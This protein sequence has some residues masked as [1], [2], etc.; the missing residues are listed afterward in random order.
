MKY[1]ITVREKDNSYQVLVSYKLSNGKWR[2]KT[3]QGFDKKSLA[4][5]YGFEIVEK[6]KKEEGLNQDLSKITLSDFYELYK[7]DMKSRLRHNTIQSLD[8]TLRYFHNLCDMPLKDISVHDILKE[9]NNGTQ[10]TSS[11]NTYLGNLNTLFNYAIKP[12]KIIGYSPTADV[13]RFKV[14]KSDIEIITKEEFSIVLSSIDKEIVSYNLQ[15]AIAYYCG[16]RYGEIC[17]LTWNDINFENNTLTIN[18]QLSLTERKKYNI[19]SV[20]SK[21]SNRTIPMPPTLKS[22]LLRYKETFNSNNTNLFELTTGNSGHI[23]RW[24]KLNGINKSIHKFRHTYA[25][26]LLANGVDIRTV[27]A[28]LGDTVSTVI[29]KYIHYTDEMR[30]NA[31]TLINDIY[32]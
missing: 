16:L 24:L 27:A 6:L 5:Q 22:I 11:K 7:R 2:Q 31:A 1:N 28:L 3:K 25:T 30:R 9:L 17:A 15:C 21:N 19:G 32:K 29:N 20:K 13:K 10:K 4:K 18:K 23:N 8:S 12:Y 14:D 26:T